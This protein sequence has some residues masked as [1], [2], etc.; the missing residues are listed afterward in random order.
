MKLKI[1]L[2]VRIEDADFDETQGFVVAAPNE[3]AARDLIVNSALFHVG[4]EGVSPWLDAR[5]SPAREIGN[6]I[7]DAVEPGVL[8]RDFHAG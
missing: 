3:A 4:D 7:R 6:A 2:I 8:L 5:L 1:Y